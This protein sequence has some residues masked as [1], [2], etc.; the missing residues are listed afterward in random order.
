MQRLRKII[1]VFSEQKNALVLCNDQWNKFVL[2]YLVQIL[3]VLRHQCFK[4]F[5]RRC[6][7]FFI[8]CP[9]ELPEEIVAPTF[10]PTLSPDIEDKV[11]TAVDA[12]PQIVLSKKGARCLGPA[13]ESIQPG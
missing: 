10:K 12:I 2:R 4:L 11:E 9:L 7:L 3:C 8:L 13:R 1:R 5:P 6:E